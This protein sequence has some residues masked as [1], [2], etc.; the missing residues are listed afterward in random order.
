M[1][2]CRL[3]LLK[4]HKLKYFEQTYLMAVAF[5]YWALH[6]TDKK[7]SFLGDSFIIRVSY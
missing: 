7:T 2:I 4:D 5:I 1:E 3:V 6:E